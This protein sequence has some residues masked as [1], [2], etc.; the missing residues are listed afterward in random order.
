MLLALLA[1]HG[2]AGCGSPSPIDDGG[3][4]PGGF[5]LAA[6]VIC[7]PGDASAFD[8]IELPIAEQQLEQA[9]CQQA[10]FCGEIGA[11]ELKQ[12]E[13]QALAVLSARHISSPYGIDY[14][15]YDDAVAKG[16]LAYDGKIAAECIDTVRN[17]CDDLFGPLACLFA[18]EPQVPVGGGCNGDIEC[19]G[20]LCAAAAADSCAGSCQTAVPIGGFCDPS[21]ARCADNSYCS[22]STLRCVAS[23]PA[24]A[25]CD[26]NDLDRSCVD[27]YRCDSGTCVARGSVGADCSGG[28]S[29]CRADLVCTYD[30]VCAVP[31]G[32]G[33]HCKS[34]VDCRH[35]LDCV[36]GVCS[37][38][39]YCPTPGGLPPGAACALEKPCADGL[40]CIG[41]DYDSSYQ[42]T[43]PGICANWLDVGSACVAHTISGCPGDMPCTN[44]VCKMSG[45]GWLGDPCDA[46]SCYERLWC[47]PTRHC[48]IPL[49][50]GAAC[51][52][53][54]G[55][56]QNPCG[57]GWC[58]S[59]MKI[60][61][62]PAC[63][64]T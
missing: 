58:D 3:V 6:S 21:S 18:F 7:P 31:A 51:T 55:N 40:A 5:D 50:P 63:S 42:T 53:P 52:P 47:D 14:T 22:S 56:E 49:A 62:L 24:G 15:L 9:F 38:T 27:G 2:M 13:T 48:A 19:V 28:S 54:T 17:H 39:N 10:A 37:A 16:Q 46:A 4:P 34:F 29:Y 26:T 36:G 8:S 57:L 1:A 60:C 59:T 12:C 41:L 25:E 44:G 61:V 35:D 45:Y 64:W 43:H 30:F 11:S 23:A 33:E 32:P 20:S